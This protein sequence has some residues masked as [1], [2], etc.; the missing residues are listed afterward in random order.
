M[1]KQAPFRMDTSAWDRMLTRNLLANVRLASVHG[2]RPGRINYPDLEANGWQHYA[3]SGAVYNNTLW[4]QP[5][6]QSYMHMSFLWAFV[7]T[8]Y[9]PFYDK[10]VAAVADTMRLYPGRWEYNEY[11]TEEQVREK[12]RCRKGEWVS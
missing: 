8:G 6:Y 1:L 9:R 2:F 4:P 12:Q 7:R 10:V 3:N 5:H 11:I